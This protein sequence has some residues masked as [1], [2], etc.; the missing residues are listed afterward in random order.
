MERQD[1]RDADR[2]AQE[3]ERRELDDGSERERE[4][5]GRAAS[6]TRED[7]GHAGTLLPLAGPERDAALA[8]KARRA[9]PAALR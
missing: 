5:R 8:R 3:D 7:A 4:G 1:V 2:P 6:K 9:A